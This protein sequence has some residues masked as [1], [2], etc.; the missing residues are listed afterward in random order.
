MATQVFRKG[1]E[2]EAAIASRLAKEAVALN[3]RLGDPTA[4]AKG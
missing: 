4:A 2:V 1:D 3:R